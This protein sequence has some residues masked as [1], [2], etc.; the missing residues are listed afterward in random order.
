M[1]LVYF[2]IMTALRQ[3]GWP[4]ETERRAEKPP[5]NSLSLLQ[6]QGVLS[7]VPPFYKMPLALTGKTV[8]CGEVVLRYRIYYFSIVVKLTGQNTDATEK[9]VACS[10]QKEGTCHSLRAMWRSTKLD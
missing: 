3:Y 4:L 7:S 10:S 8:A 5:K 6:M 9:I 1:T 2:H